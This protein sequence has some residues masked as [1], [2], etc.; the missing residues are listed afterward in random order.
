MKEI[1]SDHKTRRGLK[2]ILDN[3]ISRLTELLNVSYNILIIYI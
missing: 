1:I 3:E 2:G